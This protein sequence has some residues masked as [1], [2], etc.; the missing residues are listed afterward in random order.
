MR[1]FLWRKG[2]LFDGFPQRERERERVFAQHVRKS[3]TTHDYY[4]LCS[5]KRVYVN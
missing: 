2:L 3:T 1:G 5:S 4:M